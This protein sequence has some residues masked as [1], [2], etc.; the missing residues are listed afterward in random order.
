MTT[1][2]ALHCAVNVAYRMNG[3][4]GMTDLEIIRNRMQQPEYIIGLDP[5]RSTGVGILRTKDDAAIGWYTKDFFSAQSFVKECFPSRSNVRILVEVS[6]A[7]RIGHKADLPE[8]TRDKMLVNTGGVK[9]EASLL[10]ESLRRDGYDVVEVSPV[11]KKK[12]TDEE[13]ELFT[14]STARAN[15]HERDAVRLAYHYKDRN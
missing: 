14:G 6:P 3:G 5:G 10:A 13:F 7:V 15:E 2:D 12:W 4:E 1:V 9:R 11:R 8:E